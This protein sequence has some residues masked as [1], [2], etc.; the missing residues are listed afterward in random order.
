MTFPECNRI[1]FCCKL[2][3]L[4]ILFLVLTSQVFGFYPFTLPNHMMVGRVMK[5]LFHVDQ[6]SCIYECHMDENC[7]SC[8]VDLSKD[9][10]GLCE[11]TKCG[12]ENNRERE[13]SL[14]YTRGVLFQQIRPSQA[15]AKVH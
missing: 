11:L 12:V 6:L 8:N 5:T 14:I 4:V 2:L 1:P 7:F 15:I 3:L 10:K 13:K 9:G